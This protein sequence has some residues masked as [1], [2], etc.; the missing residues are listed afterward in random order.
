MT[1]DFD[2]FLS[3]NSSDRPTV[4]ELAALDDEARAVGSWGET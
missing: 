3:Y 2:V 4:V 1:Q